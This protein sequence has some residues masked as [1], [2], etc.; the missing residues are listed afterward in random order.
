MIT[1]VGLREEGFLDKLSRPFKHLNLETLPKK[2][3]TII[4][5]VERNQNARK[6]KHPI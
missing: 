2:Y 4:H 3:S 5:L 1:C 6:I